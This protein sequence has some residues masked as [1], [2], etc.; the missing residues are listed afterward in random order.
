MD[1]RKQGYPVLYLEVLD[2]GLLEYGE[3]F[4]RQKALVERRI[5][6]SSPDCL[7][8]VEHP[9]VVTIGRSGSLE[10]LRISKEALTQ[11]G[12]A[13]Y[14]VDRGGMAT[15]HGPGQL[16]AYPILKLKEKNLHFFL[17]TLQDALARVLRIYGLKPE[18]KD[19]Q[20]GLWLHSAKV[21]SVGIAVRRWVTYHGV[22]LNVSLD[23]ERF[24]CI[25][26][27]GHIDEKITSME[28][29]LGHPVDMSEVKKSFTEVLCALFGYAQERSD[30]GKGS[31]HP[32]WLIRA[33]PETL[34]IDRMEERLRRFEL[35]TVCE[36]A[37]CPNLGECFA[38]GTATFMILGTRCTRGCRFCAVDKGRPQRVDPEEPDRVARMAQGL[39]LRYV[40]VTSVTRDDLPDGGAEQFSRTIEQIRRYSPDAGVEVL[41]PDFK[42]SLAAL[43]KVC[44]ARPDTFN[45]NIE[46]VASLYPRVRPEARYHRSLGVLEYAAREGMLVKSG[47]ML[48][49]GETREEVVKTLIDLRRTGCQCLTIGQYLAPSKDHLPVTRFVPPGEFEGW[50]QKARSM[51]FN[52]VA[53]GPLVRS[54]YRAHEMFETRPEV[55]FMAQ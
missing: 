1:N 55:S 24:S 5:A 21:A 35:S 19:G 18:F 40:V 47:L 45:H 13:L 12:V 27:C 6:G 26:P 36:S 33:A 44:E 4:L 22:A 30:G 25:I 15:Y 38:R 39:S 54:S 17:S 2:W 52:A 31:K 42:G 8:L 46:T 41:V 43:R 3:A 28:R 7:V 10:D 20:P 16:V 32:A 51:G 48:G 50:A 37:R 29:E 23:P 49:L 9:P 14:H 53:A 11:E 34:A